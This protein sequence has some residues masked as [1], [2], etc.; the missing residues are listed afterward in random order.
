ME[1]H[2]AFADRQATDKTCTYVASHPSEKHA[3]KFLRVRDSSWRR[4]KE[5]QKN[6]PSH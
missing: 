2:N 1:A 6:D 3:L 4:L 5:W